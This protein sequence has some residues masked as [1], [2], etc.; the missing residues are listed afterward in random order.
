MLQN[1]DEQTNEL[2]AL[3]I[4]TR[5][6]RQVTRSR[7]SWLGEKFHPIP[8]TVPSVEPETVS[9]TS[10]MMN[11]FS[12]KLN[13]TISNLSHSTRSLSRLVYFSIPSMPTMPTVPSLFSS[14]PSYASIS[15]TASSSSS[16]SSDSSSATAHI[17]EKDQE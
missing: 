2:N 9:M 3:L 13:K 14:L 15:L 8:T 5:L 1:P 4:L 10:S 6:L 17:S 11:I 12:N 7:K 16:S